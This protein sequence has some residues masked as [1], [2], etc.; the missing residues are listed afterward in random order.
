MNL[1][2]GYYNPHRREEYIKRAEIDAVIGKVLEIVADAAEESFPRYDYYDDYY[3]AADVP[4]EYR[5]KYEELLYEYP[6][7]ELN[8]YREVYGDKIL[9][10]LY[11][12][13]CGYFFEGGEIDDLDE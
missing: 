13:M 5:A 8:Y 6:A 1:S 10:E 11:Q 9:D 2:S 3:P 12:E 7:S 4:A